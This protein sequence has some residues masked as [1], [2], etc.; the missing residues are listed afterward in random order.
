MLE[1]ILNFVKKKALILDIAMSDVFLIQS[2]V[3][4]LVVMQK[5]ETREGGDP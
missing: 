1:W 3:L 4:N 5:G 2:P